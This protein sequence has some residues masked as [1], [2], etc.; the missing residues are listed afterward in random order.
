M[1]SVSK[2]CNT[3]SQTT[4][5]KFRSFSNLNNIKN[6]TVDSHAVSSGLIE[7]KSESP[8]RPSTVTCTNFKFNLP[9]G[10]EPT[11]V[12]VVYRH[13]KDKGTDWTSSNKRIMNI[14]APTVS[15]VGVSGFSGKGVAPTTT[16]TSQ[17]KTFNVTGKLTR[18]QVNSTGFG[19]KVDYPTNS[20]AYNGYMRISYIYITVEYKLSS[21][22]VSVKK[23]DGG[24]NGDPYTVQLSISNKNLTSYNPTLT[25]TTPLGF[26]FNSANG[27]G[28]ITSVN[29][30][31]FTWNPQLK[32]SVGTSSINVVFDTNITFPSGSSSYT[33]TFTL[34]ES[35]NGTNNSHT[36]TITPKPSEVEEEED[37]S[38]DPTISDKDVNPT[39][40]NIV[41]ATVGQEITNLE[42]LFNASNNVVFMFPCGADN[43][44]IEEPIDDIAEFYDETTDE[45]YPVTIC[46]PNY[47]QA[48]KSKCFYD[49]VETSSLNYDK[50]RFLEVGKYILLVY[51]QVLDPDLSWAYPSFWYSDY[52]DSADLGKVFFEVKPEE[53]SLTI[54]Y[55]NLLE[56]TEEEKDRLGEGY[57]YIV[58]SFLKNTTGDVYNRDWYKNKRIGV[59]NNPITD[60]ITV[61]ETEDPETGEIIE[62][63]T[64]ST[65][66][67]SLSLD[68][69]FTYAEYWS[70]AL[71][72]V[73][74]YENL[75]CEF[76]YNPNY[77]LYILITGEYPGASSTYHFYMG[78]ISYTEPCII[79]KT[80]YKQH[81]ENGTYPVPIENLL[82]GI[83]ETSIGTL[84]T[85]STIVFYDNPV[86]DTFGT[87]ET[88]SIRGIEV[89]GN[90]EQ[91]NELV[92]N[93]SLVNPKGETGTRTTI[94]NN[95]NT[96]VDGDDSFSLGG[97]GDNWAT[98]RR[99]SSRP[100]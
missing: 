95:E 49:Y 92:L 37:P 56:P 39:L 81:E 15:L 38:D 11:K 61:T 84:N 34:S 83:A 99:D 70:G 43:Q 62:T 77:P 5:G 32:S 3:V 73:N 52:E 21:Y 86:E 60:N 65:D 31:T 66:Y 50:F 29:S 90:I 30:R 2:Y 7:G 59:F 91:S 22:S 75:E 19:A 97:I 88:H 80:Q 72:N 74:V 8:N 94:I 20:N 89:T 69:I 51:R 79:E 45:W 42:E 44:P 4:G 9:V 76:T 46:N 6:N 87:D 24:Y 93:A 68:E 82:N 23:V 63:I 18:A 41:S 25:L 47:E 14:P 57:T 58:Q 67:T 28:S 33:G 54:P 78:T 100:A 12:T 27:T 1:A 40:V 53:S 17:T 71:S 10:A 48:G 16:M 85:T 98:T 64:D 36:A 13:R 26:S 96:T 35:L 55:F